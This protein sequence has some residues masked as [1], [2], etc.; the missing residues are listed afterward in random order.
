MPHF[1]V[2]LFFFSSL[3]LVSSIP[4]VATTLLSFFFSIYTCHY[5]MLSS[6]TTSPTMY[7]DNPPPHYKE[8]ARSKIRECSNIKSSLPTL[9]PIVTWLPKYNLTWL[10]SDFISGLTLGCIVVPQAMAYGNYL[11]FF[12]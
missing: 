12:L 6:T 4:P 9:F 7:I 2:Y 3:H 11:F 1:L 8:Q 5:I 10:W